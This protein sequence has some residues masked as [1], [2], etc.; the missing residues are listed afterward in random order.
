M[1]GSFIAI[2]FSAKPEYRAAYMGVLGVTF[3]CASV[4]GPLM[5]GALTDE[6]SWRWCIWINLPIGLLAAVMILAFLSQPTRALTTQI[7]F[8]KKL[9]NMDLNGSILVAGALSYF[10]LAMHWAGFMSWNSAPVIGSLVGFAALTALFVINERVMGSKSMIQSHL[11]RRGSITLN[12]LFAFFL[13]GLY[14]PLL[15]SL[16][17][18]LQSVNNDTA[19]ESGLRLIPLVLGISV[20]TM[21]SNAMLT[22]WIHYTPF[23][24]LGALAG[25]IGV[26]GIYT[27]DANTSAPTWVG[28]E[29]LTAVG[30]GLALQVPMIANQA[31]VGLDDIPAAT[32]IS[33]FM[34]N[35]GT[36]LFVAAGETAFTNGLITG[37]KSTAPNVNPA[38]VVSA[39][40]TQ[41]RA[42]FS[43]TD[44][45]GILE[46]YLHGCKIS[47]ICSVACGCAAILLSFVSAAPSSAR[48][49]RKWAG[50]MH[51]C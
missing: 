28:L 30:I 48:E 31:A 21:V 36:S 9:L 47:H 46:A 49:L 50:K 25:T 17:I 12:A 13:A 1:T 29:I 5:G 7:R 8:K 26:S 39:G 4:V 19:A 51:L 2:A 6:L 10:V 20:F 22:W 44:L 11:L 24:L 16:L 33:L 45:P 3:G 18:Q 41:L 15:Y 35:L 38:L 42:S 14:F 40:I 27:F 43:S 32:S 23:L 34:E 37:L